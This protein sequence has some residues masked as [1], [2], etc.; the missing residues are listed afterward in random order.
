MPSAVGATS[1]VGVNDMHSTLLRVTSLRGTVGA[2]TQHSSPQ[3]IPKE[4]VW[5]S[6]LL[7]YKEKTIVYYSGLLT[8]QN[9]EILRTRYV[10]PS[11]LIHPTNT[12]IKFQ[13]LTYVSEIYM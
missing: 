2:G 4:T 5:S 7:L 13:A 9:A 3:E 6:S 10:T 1:G 8:K 11:G 12:T